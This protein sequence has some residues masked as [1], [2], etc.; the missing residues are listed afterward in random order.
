MWIS[1]DFYLDEIYNQSYLFPWCSV[2][3]KSLEKQTS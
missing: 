2:I 1:M 3:K